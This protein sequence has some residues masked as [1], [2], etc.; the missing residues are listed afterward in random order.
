MWLQHGAGA[1]AHEEILRGVW[2]RDVDTKAAGGRI[3]P[4]SISG[5]LQVG[6]QSA[7]SRGPDTT[8]KRSTGCAFDV[9][10]RAPLVASSFGPET[11]TGAAV[12]RPACFR[13]CRQ[14]LTGQ[15]N[16]PQGRPHPAHQRIGKR[17]SAHPFTSAYLLR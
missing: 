15:D 2:G 17:W 16:Q 11:N 5:L 6:Q 3:L 12:S 1:H 14:P 13:C 4:F 8:G 7:V 10:Q 9:G